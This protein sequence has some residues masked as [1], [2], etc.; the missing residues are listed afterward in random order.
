MIK[1]YKLFTIQTC[2][3]C[4]EIK[5]FLAG[6][7]LK[8]EEINATTDAGF[9]EAKKHNVMAAPTVIFFDGNGK[10]VARAGTIEEIKK[11]LLP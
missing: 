1:A 4:P 11:L 3:K 10:E 6:T 9:E 5:G 8:G 2:T 7:G